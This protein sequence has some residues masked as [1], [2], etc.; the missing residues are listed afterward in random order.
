MPNSDRRPAA[1]IV[2]DTSPI[3]NLASVDKLHLLR[4]LYAEIVVPRLYT[5]SFP[6]KES[7]LTRRYRAEACLHHGCLRRKNRMHS[8]QRG[9]LV[10]AKT[11]AFGERPDHT[12]GLKF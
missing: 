2:S 5:R 7:S 8:Y 4:D 9:H 1:L 3:I 6:G 10:R 12:L 11:C